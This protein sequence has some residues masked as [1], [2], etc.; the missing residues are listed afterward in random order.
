[1]FDSGGDWVQFHPLSVLHDPI[2]W[3]SFRSW[4]CIKL[5]GMSNGSIIVQYLSLHKISPKRAH[6]TT[7][8]AFFICKLKLW[9]EIVIQKFVQY[10]YLTILF[11]TK[12]YRGS[13]PFILLSFLA[14]SINCKLLF[15][16]EDYYF[17]KKLSNSFLI[18]SQ[19]SRCYWSV[20]K[21]DISATLIGWKLKIAW[22]WCTRR[23][24]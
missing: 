20:V 15:W 14:L 18:F 1:M 13:F 5:I 16:P 23:Y 4:R 12:L 21:E 8:D 2:T 22:R 10:M 9:S 6:T 19:L 7:L 24:R 11:L 17:E 3:L